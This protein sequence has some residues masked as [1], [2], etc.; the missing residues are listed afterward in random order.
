MF[1]PFTHSFS[2]FLGFFSCFSPRSTS[3]KE[4]G[5]C[6]EARAVPI[7]RKGFLPVGRPVVVLGE[8]RVL[9]WVKSWFALIRCLIVQPLASPSKGTFPFPFPLS[10]PNSPVIALAAA[11]VEGSC[12]VIFRSN[13]PVEVAHDDLSALLG[14]TKLG[15]FLSNRVR[16][17][18]RRVGAGPILRSALSWPLMNSIWKM[19]EM[20]TFSKQRFSLSWTLWRTHRT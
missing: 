19:L 9:I 12:G 14:M 20:T 5:L 4:Q 1:H 7:G 16:I 6:F 8:F 10:R 13:P 11:A 15:G 18:V 17:M 3:G 2:P